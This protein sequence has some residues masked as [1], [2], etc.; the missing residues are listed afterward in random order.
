MVNNLSMKCNKIISF[1]I[2]SCQNNKHTYSAV[3][4]CN[5]YFTA[6]FTNCLYKVCPRGQTSSKSLQDTCMWKVERDCTENCTEKK[7]TP[8][9]SVKSVLSQLN[10]VKMC[11]KGVRTARVWSGTSLSDYCETWFVSL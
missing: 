10:D 2:F 7:K 1:M 5:E 3:S 9:H 8:P 6:V 11:F 4:L